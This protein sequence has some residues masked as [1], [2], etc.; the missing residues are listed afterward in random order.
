[1][2]QKLWLPLAL[3]LVIS[4]C[5]APAFAAEKLSTVT[6]VADL[7]ADAE[8]KIKDLEEKVLKDSDS[9]TK[10]KKKAL[11]QAAG[12]LAVVAQA[13]AEHDEDSALKKSAADLRDAAISI[14]KSASYEDAKKGLEAAK[15]AAGGKASGAKVEHPW[16]KLID[17]DSLMSEVNVRNASL[18]KALRKAPEDRNAVA[19]DASVLAVLAL[20]IESDTHEVKDK[21]DIEKW[22]KYSKDLQKSMSE[23]SATIKAGDDAKFKKLF[24]E[25]GKSCGACHNEIRDK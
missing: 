10:A 17:M 20:V 12:A 1:V 23:I 11:P 9:Y 25:S 19:R 16:D 24:P 3:T 13:I 8:G 14:A 21:A 2:V 18:R 6:P 7:V 22:K 15:A 4:A 5:F